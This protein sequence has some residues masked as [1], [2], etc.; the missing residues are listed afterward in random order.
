MGSTR[1]DF[2]SNLGRI[3]VGYAGLSCFANTLEA[4]IA[5]PKNVRLGTDLTKPLIGMN[6]LTWQGMASMPTTG[7]SYGDGAIAV[8]YVKG[9]RRFLSVKA[10]SNHGPASSSWKASTIVSV[11]TVGVQ[12]RLAV[13]L[14]RRRQDGHQRRADGHREG[15]RG[16]LRALGVLRPVLLPAAHGAVRVHPAVNLGHVGHDDAPPPPR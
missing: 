14:H 2:L 1:R 5:A 7:W 8:R 10:T 12:P 15:H 3:G 4:Q 13:L 9:Q 11:G 6:D 16:R